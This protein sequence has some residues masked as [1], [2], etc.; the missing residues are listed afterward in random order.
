VN[1]LQDHVAN[2]RRFSV[3]NYFESGDQVSVTLTISGPP[4]PDT[5]SV[6]KFFTFR[7][8]T[9]VITQMND[10]VDVLA[11]RALMSEDEDEEE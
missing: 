2:G 6:T 4:I 5:V 1:L 9:N 7:P 10:G 11:L 3:S 8:G